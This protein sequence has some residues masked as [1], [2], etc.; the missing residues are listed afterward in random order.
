MPE[1]KRPRQSNPAPDLSPGEAAHTGGQSL[2][3]FRLG[4]L[5][6]LD[7]I[8]RRLRLDDFLRQYLPPRMPAKRSPPPPASFSCSRTFS[9][10][11]NPCM[12]SANGRVATPPSGS[13]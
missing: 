10:P 6:I 8:I 3:S 5:P 9:S 4:A 1:Q 7:R 12:A 11:V 2:K 13:L